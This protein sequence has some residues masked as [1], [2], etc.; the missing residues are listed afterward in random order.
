[1]LHFLE[2]EGINFVPKCVLYDE[3][4]NIIIESYVGNKDAFLGDLNKKQID[5][6]MKYMQ[7]LNTI[8]YKKFVIFCKANKH[9]P[10]KPSGSAYKSIKKW[11]I[12][13]F[14]LAKKNGADDFIINWIEPRLKSNILAIKRK[15]KFKFWLKF[16]F[17]FKKKKMYLIH[18]DMGDNY[19]IGKGTLDI[20]DWES[21]RL[22]RY[23]NGLP[24]FAFVHGGITLQQQEYMI[25]SYARK[26]KIP[27]KNIREQVNEGMRET[28]VNDVIWAAMRYSEMRQKK[29]KGWKKYYDITLERIKKYENVFEK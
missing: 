8:D 24:I 15:N 26:S 9:K 2:K 10:I 6:A 23:G 4:E 22:A 11:G 28:M 5:L 25:K 18:G 12:D 27:I 20:I 3:N 29:E 19:R 13:R 14:E 7:K 16:N 17:S 21:A 1:M